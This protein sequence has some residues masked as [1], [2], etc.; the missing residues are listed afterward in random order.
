MYPT[1]GWG[2][3]ISDVSPHFLGFK[4][5]T[6]FNIDLRFTVIFTGHIRTT[7]SH[8]LPIFRYSEYVQFIEDEKSEPQ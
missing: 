8:S 5:I 7:C 3:R 4:T 6:Y 2:D 1:F